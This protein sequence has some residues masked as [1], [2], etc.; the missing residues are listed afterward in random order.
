MGSFGI[1]VS[2]TSGLVCFVNNLG[3]TGSF[4]NKAA[5]IVT[6]CILGTSNCT[7]TSRFYS[8]I[9][10]LIGTHFIVGP[11]SALLINRKI[12]LAKSEA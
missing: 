5:A 4:A 10:A 12:V 11:I 2:S 3:M 6:D 9:A 7:S 8:V 1:A